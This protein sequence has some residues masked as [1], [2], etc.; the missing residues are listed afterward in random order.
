[1]AMTDRNPRQPG[2]EG[3]CGLLGATDKAG[4][5]LHPVCGGE[6]ARRGIIDGTPAQAV[7]L[8]DSAWREFVEA[9]GPMGLIQ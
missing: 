6:V 9:F 7:Y 2:D 5:A 3:N 1:M 8:C 4:L